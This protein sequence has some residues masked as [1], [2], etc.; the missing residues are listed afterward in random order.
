MES[1]NFGVEKAHC[2]S[3]DLIPPWDADV[4][5]NV[6]LSISQNLEEPQIP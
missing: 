1:G 3:D 5:I 4:G 6:F 2:I